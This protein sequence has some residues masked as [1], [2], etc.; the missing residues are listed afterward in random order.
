MTDLGDFA[1]EL[2][3]RRL[4]N[5]NDSIDAEKQN[6]IAYSLGLAGF[7]GGVM[8]FLVDWYDGRVVPQ[9]TVQSQ[10]LDWIL[11]LGVAFLL[12][13]LAIISVSL[14]ARGFW[15]AVRPYEKQELF[16]SLGARY[17]RLANY[18]FSLFLILFSYLI[19]V[20]FV[21]LPGFF[22][23]TAVDTY[24]TRWL[25]KWSWIAAGPILL[26]A[27][28]VQ[29]KIG[30]RL[31]RWLGVWEFGALARIRH[32][33]NYLGWLLLAVAM[34]VPLWLYRLE[35]LADQSIYV[36]SPDSVIVIT[37]VFGGQVRDPKLLQISIVGQQHDDW[38][39]LFVTAPTVE[40]GTLQFYGQASALSVGQHE[41]VATYPRSFFGASRP[42][43]AT[44]HFTVLPGPS[45]PGLHR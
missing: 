9:E 23:F 20:V 45:A 5:R 6:Q 19:Y 42:A 28:A 2:A 29:N 40:P 37:V 13:M 21:G 7:A 22:V 4:L 12:V 38:P 30:L 31:F 18:L 41:V 32:A 43:T 27:Y 17:D 15:L 14:F 1:S 25:Q 8:L 34:V 44:A 33:V 11:V 35:I 36:R 16:A 26:A 39:R 10:I 24:T 3:L